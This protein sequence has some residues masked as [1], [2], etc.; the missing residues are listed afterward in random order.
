MCFDFFDDDFWDLDADDF[1][2]VGGIWGLIEEEMVE[3]KRIRQEDDFLEDDEYRE[4]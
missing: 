1:A 2:W 4:E 3:E